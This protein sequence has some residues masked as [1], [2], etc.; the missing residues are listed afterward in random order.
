MFAIFNEERVTQALYRPT[1]IVRARKLRTKAELSPAMS[2]YPDRIPQETRWQASPRGL[3]GFLSGVRAALREWRRRKNGRLELA[4]LALCGLRG[5]ASPR[6]GEEFDA[7]TP[8]LT[9]REDRSAQL[10]RGPE[11]LGNRAAANYRFPNRLSRI[12]RLSRP[13][14]PS[15]EV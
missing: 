4:R 3:G 11:N 13:H 5:G 10:G 2:S 12:R 8:R 9:R 15:Y 1:G 14:E 7:A 6:G